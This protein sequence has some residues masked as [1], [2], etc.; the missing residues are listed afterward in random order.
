MPHVTSCST[1][2]FAEYTLPDALEN[3]AGLGFKQVSIAHMSS[4]CTHYDHRRENPLDVLALLNKYD[5]QAT[6]INHSVRRRGLQG[7]YR[8]Y[9]AEEIEEY[10]THVC[11]LIDH[12]SCLKL[13]D[14]LVS[15]GHRSNGPDDSNVRKVFATV[16]S[17]V[18]DHAAEKGVR[19]SVELLHVYSVAYDLPTTIDFF[20]AAHSDKLVTTLDSSHWL[21]SKYDINELFDHL[22][23]R[24]HHV[25]L[26][27]ARGSDTADFKQQLEF[28]PGKGEVDFQLLGTVLDQ[29]GYRDGIV[30]EMEHRN[31]LSI[32][33]INREYQFGIRH[34]KSCGWQF[35]PGI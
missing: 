18:A 35:P 32:A 24:I 14:F 12:A 34:L 13:S 5:L 2:G 31:G 28:T 6:S 25:H 22:G 3:I 29:R 15:I 19:L 9:Y 7:A 16:L 4:Y 8:A 17:D 30:L 10:R 23:S 26:R 1:L 33:Q 21:V 20:H 27:D 11:E